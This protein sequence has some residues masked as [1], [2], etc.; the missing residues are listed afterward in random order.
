MQ[1][2][3]AVFSACLAFFHTSEAALAFA[4]NPQDAGWHS[5]CVLCGVGAMS[6]C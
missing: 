6:R 4:F 1:R 5:A 2:P 3:F